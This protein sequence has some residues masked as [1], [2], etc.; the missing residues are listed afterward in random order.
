MVLE[1]S[2][3]PSVAIVVFDASIK[4]NIATFIVHIHMID[5]PLTKTIHYIVNVMSTEA[6]LFAIRCGINQILRFNNI[7]KIIIIT[8]SIHI[9]YKIF[10]YLVHPYQIQ[11][12]AILLD[13]CAFFNSYANNSIEFWECPNY[14]NWYLH[15]KVNQETKTFNLI[16]LFLNKNS[17]D[18]SKK[19]KSNNILNA[20]KMMFQVSNL[21]GNYFLDLLDDDVNIIELTY[22]KRGSWLK[23]IGYLNLLCGQATRAITNHAPI[24]EYRLRFFPRKEFKCSCSKYPIESR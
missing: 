21:K 11:S 3:S 22:V 15:K 6:K 7:S 14:L 16:L 20:W 13:L 1:F 10:N 24:S 9:A 2:L 23:M 18:F 8:D 4:N 19:N 17:W 12:A 5:K